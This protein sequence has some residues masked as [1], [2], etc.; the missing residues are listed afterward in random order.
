V[1][2]QLRSKALASL[3]LAPRNAP[4]HFTFVAALCGL[5]LSEKVLD[6]AFTIT[7]LLGE[8]A[9]LPFQALN[10]VEGGKVRVVAAV[11]A[12]HRIKLYQGQAA[13]RTSGQGVRMW[14]HHLGLRAQRVV[15]D[16]EVAPASRHGYPGAG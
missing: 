7:P 1:F 10:L 14:L 12:S 8:S 13:C 15:R 9:H 4:G 3:P 11:A 6:V 2:A 5:G 16:V